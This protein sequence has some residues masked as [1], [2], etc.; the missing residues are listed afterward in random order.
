[1]TLIFAI[2]LSSH[3]VGR[4]NFS[5][6]SLFLEDILT[7]L[8]QNPKYLDTG[9]GRVRNSIRDSLIFELNSQ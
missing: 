9:R 5:N 6:Y 8:K 3:E 2:K 7:E 1:M 4:S